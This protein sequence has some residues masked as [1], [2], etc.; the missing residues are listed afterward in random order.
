MLQVL[1]H[2]RTAA[3]RMWCC[4]W[5]GGQHQS[6]VVH[7]CALQVALSCL[8]PPRHAATG[9][10]F[11]ASN[12][13]F[14]FLEFSRVFCM[15]RSGWKQQG[16]MA[17]HANGHTTLKSLW[18]EEAAP[19]GAVLSWKG[20]TKS[21]QSSSQVYHRWCCPVSFLWDMLCISLHHV[22][23]TAS[24]SCHRSPCVFFC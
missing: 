16:V 8:I 21:M 7:R 13:Q 4:S 2:W 10:F 9:R 18:I 11:T 5:N 3:P 14:F 22:T 23:W 6:G 20:R 24:Q 1:P 19:N 12:A 17:L 15:P